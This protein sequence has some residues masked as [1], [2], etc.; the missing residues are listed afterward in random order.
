MPQ[1]SLFGLT[2]NLI[3][4]KDLTSIDAKNIVSF[5]DGTIFLLKSKNQ[6]DAYLKANGGISID[7]QRLNN[8]TLT[9]NGKNNI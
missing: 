5:A 8:N 3:Y 7:M 6:N 1:G 4:K 9:L 2:L